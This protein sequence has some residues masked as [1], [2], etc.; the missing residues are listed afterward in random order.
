VQA[1]SLVDMQ[2]VHTG[3]TA[4][5]LHHDSLAE[6]T[7]CGRSCTNHHQKISLAITCSMPTLPRCAMHAWLVVAACMQCS[8][9]SA[10]IFELF[11]VMYQAGWMPL[12][13]W[14]LPAASRLEAANTECCMTQQVGRGH[15]RGGPG[16]AA[17]VKHARC[18]AHTMHSHPLQSGSHAT[19][20]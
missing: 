12:G 4:H 6:C 1:D 19:R 11:V 13:L 5:L 16:G 9:C 15:A 3:T 7:T 20:D 14:A 18:H 2:Q 10:D 8:A 17:R